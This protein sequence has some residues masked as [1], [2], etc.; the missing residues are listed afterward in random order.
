MITDFKDK[1]HK[2]KKKYKKYIT[3]TTILKSFHT[4][5]I[6]ATKSSSTTLSP[7]GNGLTILPISTAIV[8]RLSIGIKVIY[9]IVM[10]RYKKYRK[11][12]EKRQ[13]INKL[14]RK[15]FQDNLTDKNEYACSYIISK[16][17]III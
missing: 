15:S 1:N 10:Q 17:L 9:E 16:F 4:F 2:S 14:Y 11:H 8:W 3:L 6:I 13:Q 5:L 12:Y 7:T